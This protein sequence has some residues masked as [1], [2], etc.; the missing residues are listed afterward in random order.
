MVRWHRPG[1]K[2]RPPA[3]QVS[4]LPL[5]QRCLHQVTC[6]D[7]LR[8][9]VRP[10]FTL[11]IMILTE[12]HRSRNNRL[13]GC[14]A[15][16]YTIDALGDLL[17]F[18]A[19]NYIFKSK[20]Q[21][22]KELASSGNQTR[23]A[24]VAGKH[25]IREPT[26]FTCYDSFWS[27]VRP[28]FK[29]KNV[30]LTTLHASTGNWIRNNSLEACSANHYTIDTL[31]DLLI[32]EARNYIFKSKIQIQKELASSGN[33]NWAASVV[34]EQSTTEPTMLACYD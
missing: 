29:L 2:P 22:Q 7:S 3:W 30:I 24:R 9:H 32:F 12:L 26:M 31:G 17:I 33:R 34:G 11:K 21:I 15:N 28:E 25:S 13:E 4:I 23:A 14:S 5:N 16:H 1:I 19:R 27:H 18:E 6:Y 10:E 20:I 8:S